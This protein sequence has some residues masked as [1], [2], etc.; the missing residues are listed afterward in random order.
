MRSATAAE[1]DARA[2]GSARMAARTRS[3]AAAIS[4][5]VAVL[6]EGLPTVAIGFSEV[7]SIDGLDV[8]PGKRLS[9][10]FRKRGRQQFLGGDWVQSYHPCR[11]LKR[12]AEQPLRCAASDAKPQA[13]R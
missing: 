6:P 7:L 4:L 11:W 12:K 13:H 8:R 1:V 10:G 2:K 9:V 5:A 3:T